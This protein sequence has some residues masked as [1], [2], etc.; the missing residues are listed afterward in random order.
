M[1]LP[2]ASSLPCSSAVKVFLPKICFAAVIQIL[3]KYLWMSSYFI[4]IARN[5]NWNQFLYRYFSI[6]LTT[7]YVQ[8]SCISHH[9]IASYSYFFRTSCNGCCIWNNCW[10]VLRDLKKH[11]ATKIHVSAENDF[12]WK[13]G[14]SKRYYKCENCLFFI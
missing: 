5:F 6:I 9:R 8:N 13:R 14:G 11:S 3:K 4:K 12:Q 10:R 1:R 2:C 7:Y